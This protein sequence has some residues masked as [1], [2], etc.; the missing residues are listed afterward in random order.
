[1][2]PFKEW[3]TIQGLYKYYNVHARAKLIPPKTRNDVF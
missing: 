3:L 2:L 1:M